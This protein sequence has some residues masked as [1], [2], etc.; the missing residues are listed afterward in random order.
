MSSRI[1]LILV[2]SMAGCARSNPE[3]PVEPPAA[4]SSSADGGAQVMPLPTSCRAAIVNGLMQIRLVDAP[5]TDV[6]QIVVTIDK[7]TAH[8]AGGWIDLG[9]HP[10]TVDL[11]QLQGGSFALLGIGALPAGHV[12]ELRL[13]VV[14]SGPNYVT[15]ADDVQHPLVVPSGDE[16]GIK[17]K[18]G[19]DLPACASGNITLDFD[20]KNSIFTHPLGA[21]AGDQWLLRPVIRLREVEADSSCPDAG[22]AATGSGAGGSGSDGQPA[23]GSAD[24]A[25][26]AGGGSGGPIC[27]PSSMPPGTPVDPCLTSPPCPDGSYCSNGACL[28]QII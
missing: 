4:A 7:V 23:A 28:P 8:L 27:T 2:L 1:A 16:S 20:G 11:L 6:K 19:F 9:T 3:H 15:T 5:S 22:S 18:G 26:S 24:G 17:I 12:T 25:T 10:V 13:S 14:D 21:G